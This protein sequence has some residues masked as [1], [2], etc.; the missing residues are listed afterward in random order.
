MKKLLLVAMSALLLAGCGGGGDAHPDHWS[1][2]GNGNFSDGSLANWD[3]ADEVS[4]M[5]KISVEDAKA[6]GVDLS[7]KNVKEVQKY[8][9]W[10][11]T[12]F[13]WGEGNPYA[14]VD[15]VKTQFKGGHAIKAAKMTWDAEGEKFVQTAW[16][17]NAGDNASFQIANLEALT[18]NLFVPH[19]AKDKDPNG[20][21]WADNP[22]ITSAAGNYTIVVAEYDVTPD[23]NTPNFGM[24]VIAAK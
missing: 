19:W 12:E 4:F 23:A 8:E 9:N 6:L 1:V 5:T 2:M 17:P 16:I 10:G 24:A 22:V 18:S 14:M 3:G 21:S 13:D 11:V 7:G 20:F 15:G